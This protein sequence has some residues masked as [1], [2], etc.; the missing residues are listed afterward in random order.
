MK[1]LVLQFEGGGGAVCAE[2]LD[3]EELLELDPEGGVIG[4]RRTPD[5]DP[6]R[7]DGARRDAP[8]GAA[9]PR[10]GLADQRAQPLGLRRGRAEQLLAADRLTV[11]TEPRVRASACA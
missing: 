7:A 9:G 2:D 1:Y 4:D 8:P 3:H 11:V 6:R 5:G 10:L